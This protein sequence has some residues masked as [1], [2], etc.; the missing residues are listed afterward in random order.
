MLTYLVVDH[1]PEPFTHR[2]EGEAVDSQ[3]PTFTPEEIVSLAEMGEVR[4]ASA[5]VVTEVNVKEGECVEEDQC[6]LFLEAMKMLN[7]V[8][9]LL[10]GRVKEVAV[11]EGQEVQQG[12]L[13]VK[14]RPR[15][16]KDEEEG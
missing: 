12:D 7:R 3:R 16:S 15:R 11:K 14:I 10:G 9:A 1:H 5:G 4:A 13:L 8:T 6:L 2:P